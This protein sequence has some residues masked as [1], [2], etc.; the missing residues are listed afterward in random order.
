MRGCRLRAIR[1]CERAQVVS[2][3]V[4]STRSKTAFEL[5][6]IHKLCSP[7]AIRVTV[8][9]RGDAKIGTGT[10]VRGN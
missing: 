4:R 3:R 9:D 10:T 8:R 2:S 6:I 7:F 1:F 5:A